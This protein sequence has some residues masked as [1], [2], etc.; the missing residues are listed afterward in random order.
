MNGQDKNSRQA[1]AS[2]SSDD[3]KKNSFYALCSRGEKKT[4]PMW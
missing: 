2:G 3:L 1:Q 4:S